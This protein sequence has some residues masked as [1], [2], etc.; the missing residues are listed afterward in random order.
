MF[1]CGFVEGLPDDVLHR[2]RCKFELASGGLKIS[3]TSFEGK[4]LTTKKKSEKEKKN[5]VRAGSSLFL[6]PPCFRFGFF[7]VFRFYAGSESVPVETIRR[8]IF[9][10]AVDNFLQPYRSHLSIG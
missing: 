1:Q 10:S 8:I 3:R 7:D 4:F 5:V 9:K 6:L 2:S